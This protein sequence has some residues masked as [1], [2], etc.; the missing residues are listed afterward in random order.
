MSTPPTVAVIGAGGVA[1]VHVPAWQELGVRLRVFSEQYGDGLRD[2]LGPDVIAGSLAEALDGAD[3]VD[4]CTPTHTH[5]EIVRAAAAAGC[6]VVCEKP[7]ALTSELATQLIADCESAGVGL[8]PAHVVRY[9]PEYAVMQRHVAA[10]G[11]GR[12]AV[13]RFSRSGAR[14]RA[15]WF[16][17]AALSGGIVM[18]QMIHDLDLARWTA[19]PVRQVFAR[20]VET[21]EVV[22][23]QVVLTHENEAL[24]YVSGAW[25]PPG[26]RFRTWFEV[27][28]SDGLVHHDSARQA[29]LTFDGGAGNDGRGLLPPRSFTESPYT[30]ELREF[31]AACT[32]GPAPRVSAADGLEAVRLA[33]AANLS[34]RTGTAVRI[35]AGDHRSVA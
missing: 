18:D 34:M 27:A 13:Q 35:T 15:A 16:A 31:L 12:I 8:Y 14:P 22:S 30:T 1:Q 32:G 6:D 21:D 5:A 3:V 2:R 28:G 26:S 20:S 9:F 29:S 10:G 25:M 4:V 11:V 24:S 33:E 17:D 23:A 19:G 7:L